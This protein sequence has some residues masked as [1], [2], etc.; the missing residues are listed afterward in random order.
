MNLKIGKKDN[1]SAVEPSLNLK[2]G[3]EKTGKL[4]RAVEPSSNLKIGKKTVRSTKHKKK[5]KQKEEQ[6]QKTET[7]KKKKS[8]KKLESNRYDFKHLRT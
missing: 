8:L 7:F 4:V 6:K 2:I 1:S 5:K 3:K